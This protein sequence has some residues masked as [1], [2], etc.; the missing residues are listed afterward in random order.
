[1]AYCTQEGIDAPALHKPQ[2][3]SFDD[4]ILR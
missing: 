1:V 4:D 3:D 2:K